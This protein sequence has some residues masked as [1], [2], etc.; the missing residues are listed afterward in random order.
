[1]NENKININW[2]IRIWVKLLLN[3]YKIRILIKWVFTY[4]RY[5]LWK[6]LKSRVMEQ[7]EK[8]LI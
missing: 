2:V 5:F 3:A 7:Y 8:I 4:L 6:I 1:M